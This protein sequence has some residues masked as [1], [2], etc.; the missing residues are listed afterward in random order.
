MGNILCREKNSRPRRVYV[1]GPRLT[2]VYDQN[3]SLIKSQIL[4]NL[5][6]VNLI[7]KFIKKSQKFK[8]KFS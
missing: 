3:V 2:T 1:K 8:F 7:D 5:K 6:L 4:S